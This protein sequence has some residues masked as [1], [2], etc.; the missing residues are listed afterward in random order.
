MTMDRRTFFRRACA[1]IGAACALPFAT[2]RTGRGSE[3]DL[4]RAIKASDPTDRVIGIDFARPGTTSQTVTYTTRQ[5]SP[6]TY[7]LTGA[8]FEP[9]VFR[10]TRV[11]S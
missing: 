9:P 8:D 5:T 10:V 3:F 11:E 7:A 6:F 2:G 4:E 1:A